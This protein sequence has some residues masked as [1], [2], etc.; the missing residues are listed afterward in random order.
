MNYRIRLTVVWASVLA[1]VLATTISARSAGV[2]EISNAAI[3]NSGLGGYPFKITAT[4]SYALT[5]NLVVPVPGVDAIDVT[6]PDPVTIDLNGFTISRTSP[7]TGFG[8][9]D[10]AGPLTV[11]NG[12]IQGFV[13]GIVDLTGAVAVTDINAIGMTY[14]LVIANAQ[15]TDYRALANLDGVVCPQGDGCL[16]SRS[17]VRGSGTSIVIETGN[18]VLTNNVLTDIGVG[19]FSSPGV[20][21]PTGVVLD[22]AI[23]TTGVS[24][25]GLVFDLMLRGG[26]YSENGILTPASSTCVGGPGVSLGDNVCNG[27][28]Q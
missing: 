27:V 9:A 19:G 26:G 4:G 10:N 2:I 25:F 20:N 13:D 7:G 8:I 17:T 18:A 24:T 5:S 3:L 23:R 14:G 11:R 21:V 16:V 1:A 28:K 22:N 12:T 15:V 6:T